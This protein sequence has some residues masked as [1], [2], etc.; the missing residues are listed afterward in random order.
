MTSKKPITIIKFFA[1]MLILGSCSKEVNCDEE[2]LDIIGKWSVTQRKRDTWNTV[3]AITSYFT[4]DFKN[5]GSA[6]S[7]ESTPIDTLGWV[8]QCEPKQ[9]HV[10]LFLKDTAGVPFYFSATRLFDIREKSS[11]KMKLA[12]DVNT[13]G[14]NPLP[15]IQ[16]IIWEMNKL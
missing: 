7:T 14:E 11:D 15:R 6:L 5:D 9:L 13:F 3:P 8:Y 12:V 1:V 2:R 4:V 10:E 16:E